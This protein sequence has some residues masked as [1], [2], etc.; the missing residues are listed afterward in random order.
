MPE[1][2]WFVALGVAVAI[3][4]TLRAVPFAL[5][6][7][8]RDSELLADV[9]R[10]MPLGALAILAVYCL[11]TID[12][13]APDR[14]VPQLVGVAVTVGLH[15]W[16]HNAVLSLVGGTLACVILYTWILP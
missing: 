11:A 12:V 3:T 4:V 7:R 2:S 10:W 13:S 14:G 5:R 9:G 8:M 6:A 1:A 15:L 16:R